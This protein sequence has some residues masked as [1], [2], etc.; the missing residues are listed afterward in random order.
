M[1][2]KIAT[3]LLFAVTGKH[4]TDSNR[5]ALMLTAD[6]KQRL[7]AEIKKTCRGQCTFAAGTK[8]TYASV[9]LILQKLEEPVRP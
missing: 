6:E 1:L 2:P 4:P 5:I 7:L 8:Y 9:G 3:F